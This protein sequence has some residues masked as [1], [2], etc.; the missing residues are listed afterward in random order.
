MQAKYDNGDIDSIT[1]NTT[2]AT[3]GLLRLGEMFCDQIDIS[4]NNTTYWILTPYNNINVWYIDVFSNAYTNKLNFESGIRPVVFL[5]EN[6]I[7]TSGD[8][9]LNNP[10]EVELRS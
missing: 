1:T 5:K 7:I 6:V 9:T 2:N 8:G 10:F 4:D 3:V